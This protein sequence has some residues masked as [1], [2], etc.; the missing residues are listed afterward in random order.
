MSQLVTYIYIYIYI[1][2]Y[3]MIIYINIYIY[4]CMNLYDAFCG[5]VFEDTRVAKPVPRTGSPI[6]RQRD[7][8][9]EQFAMHL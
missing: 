2:A 1:M 9:D 4:I 8:G 3:N 6:P 5:F 7:S